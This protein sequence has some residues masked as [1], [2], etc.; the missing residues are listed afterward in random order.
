M[1]LEKQHVIQEVLP[2]KAG[3]E[4]SH[5]TDLEL[6]CCVYTMVA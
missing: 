1:P 6:Y 5:S 3:G 4:R 2:Q